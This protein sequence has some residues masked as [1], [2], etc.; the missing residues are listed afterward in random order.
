MVFSVSILGSSSSFPEIA[1]SE[2]GTISA[3]ETGAAGVREFF[4]A[5][6]IPPLKKTR[7]QLH[8]G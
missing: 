8:R 6:I 4:V 2:L 3:Q 7:P 1:L 5:S